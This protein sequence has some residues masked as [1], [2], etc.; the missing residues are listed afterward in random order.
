M[1]EKL[2]KISPASIDRLLKHQKE[3]LRLNRK[4]R[5]RKNPLIY[6]KIPVKAGGWDRD[7]PG[8]VQVD[9]VEHCGQ[10]A[11]GY[12]AN[13]ISLCDIATGWWEGEVVLGRGQKR[14]LSAITLARKRFPFKWKE[15]HPDNDSSFI[16][17]HLLGWCEK[18]G[19]QFS[20]SRP[21]R[22]NDNCFVEQKNST[23]IRNVLGHLRYDTE[24]EI[25]II[26]S[27]YRNELRLYKNFFQPVMKL[28][29]KVRDK[30]KI[31][32]RYDTPRTPYQ[33]IM[34]SSYI[35]DTTKSRLRE[36]YLSL[37]PA[38]LKRGIEKKLKKLYKVYQE[39][40]NKKEGINP[41]KRQRPFTVT[42]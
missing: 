40:N 25:E 42:F 21:Y 3:Y 8:W 39:K 1:K 33:R 15:I 13:T 9:L 2:K 19:I 29:E 35:P 6:Q 17:W 23:H 24:K 10:S 27:L 7:L 5:R 16:N 41:C 30:G 26:N 12:F 18:E 14:C 20:R 37:N 4:Y 38:E 28:K 32:R 36:L 11:S 31:H 22:K 34:E